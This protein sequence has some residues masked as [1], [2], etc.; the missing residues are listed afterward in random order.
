MSLRTKLALWLAAAVIPVVAVF[1]VV[2]YLALRHGMRERIAHRMT[3]RHA[4]LAQQRCARDPSSF[5][6][7][8][9]RLGIFAY[10]ADLRSANP[11]APVFPE[12]LADRLADG[13][14]PVTDWNVSIPD[15]T[16]ATALRV[17]PERED[18]AVFL[19]AW[20][21]G[22][23]PDTGH[24]VR[25]V[26]VQSG[27]A[28]LVL[29]AVGLLIGGPLVRR[30]RKLTDEVREAGDGGYQIEAEVDSADELGDLA[31]AFNRAGDDVRET[32][33]QLEARDAALREYV[34]N[35]THDLAVPVTVL[36][37]RLTRLR[38]QLDEGETIDE[39]LVESAIEETQYVSSMIANVG[40]VARLE[41]GDSAVERHPV[42]LCDVVERVGTRFEP[43]A[44][45]Q[46]IE[47]NW[48]VPDGSLEVEA[49]STLVEQ[50]VGNCVQNAI[51]YN[52][53]GGHVGLVLDRREGDGFAIRIVDDGPG[54]PEEIVDRLTE[55]EFRH[56]Q[57]RERRP[58]GQGFGLSI[59]RQV[60][61]AHD[62][63]L[64]IS[65]RPD[66]GLEI[67]ISSASVAA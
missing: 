26:L 54:V 47:F 3:T 31:R 29:L 24:V 30:I 27:G 44:A 57:A 16:G 42:D 33:E 32:I 8:R 52:D 48:A 5:H 55:R 53:D 46:E 58:S 37:H 39:A 40:I 41:A 67:L 9:H 62:W 2:R 13:S 63:A 23:G 34:A 1:S 61:D 64:E 7:E 4:S 45:Q 60:V 25:R 36:Q 19:F 6:V 38:R 28:G 50:A 56:Q 51:E 11:D 21:R 49:D 22:F 20:R 14:G 12:D 10:D 18:C 17:E 59:T 65:N 15:A 66:G 43:L 35:T